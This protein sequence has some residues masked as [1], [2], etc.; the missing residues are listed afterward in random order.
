MVEYNKINVK[1]LDSQLNRLKSAVKNQA[2]ATLRM[3][4]KTLN[5]N[6]L[7]QEL[8]L[9]T[10]EKNN[11][12]NRFEKNMSTDI[13]LSRARS[14]KIIQSVGFLGLSLS[15]L[16]GP[17]IKVAVPLAKNILASLGITAAASAINAR[18]RKKMQGS[19][20]TLQ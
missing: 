6:N 12:R 18:T 15:K 16:T 8:L 17:L 1:L 13:K 11:L 7:P 10:R 5:E 2:A 3:N 4:M 9:T 20:A 14:S 19:G